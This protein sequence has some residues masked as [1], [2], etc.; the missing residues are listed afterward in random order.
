MR[1]F[2]WR[3]GL[4]GLL[5]LACATVTSY[6]TLSTFSPGAFIIKRQIGQLGFATETEWAYKRDGELVTPN[7]LDPSQPKRTIDQSGISVRLLTLALMMVAACFSRSSLVM[8][9]SWRRMSA[10]SNSSSTSARPRL[11]KDRIV[12]R[13]C[14]SSFPSTWADARRL[15]LCHRKLSQRL[16]IRVAQRAAAPRPTAF[17]FALSGRTWCRR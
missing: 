17:G 10:Q 13:R 9:Q 11:R 8:P 15:D 14:L 4:L 3:A 2:M 1:I 7:P 5:P 16:G 12:P 6:S